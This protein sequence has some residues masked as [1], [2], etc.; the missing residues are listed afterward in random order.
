MCS[1]ILFCKQKIELRVRGEQEEVRKILIFLR[2]IEPD[3]LR[4][5]K[6]KREFANSMGSESDKRNIN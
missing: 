4:R 3:T 6:P 2:F 5:N 1:K